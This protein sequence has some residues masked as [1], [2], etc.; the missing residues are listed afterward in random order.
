MSP[1]QLLFREITSCERCPRL[2]RF[3]QE[4]AQRKRKQYT[5]WDYWGRPVPGYGNPQAKLLIVGLAPAAHGGN[6]TGRVFTGDKSAEFLMQCLFTT[7]FSNQP[8]SLSSNDGLELPNTYMTPVLKCVPPQDKPRS[9][10]LTNCFP[11]FQQELQQL[12]HLRVLLALGRIA[13]DA[14]LRF[15]RQ[16]YPFKKKDYPFRHGG[17]YRLPSGL[18]IVA[19]YHPSPRNVNTRRLTQPMMI[20]LL[21]QLKELLE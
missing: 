16:Q 17:R 4:I 3:R 10:E 20:T 12:K 1:S 8:H 7:G 15:A 9:E 21:S 5:H 14:C 11:F 6:R 19:S 13:F 2:V 18:W